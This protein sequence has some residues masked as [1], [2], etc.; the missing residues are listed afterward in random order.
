MLTLIALEECYVQDKIAA[1]PLYL[2]LLDRLA[3][4]GS[5]LDDEKCLGDSLQLLQAYGTFMKEAKAQFLNILASPEI[6]PSELTAKRAFTFDVEPDTLASYI[7]SG[8]S[9]FLTAPMS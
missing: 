2:R 5:A 8:A 7:K 3:I 1:L 9:S 4:N 6:L